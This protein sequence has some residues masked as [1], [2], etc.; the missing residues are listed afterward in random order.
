MNA[1][2]LAP[3]RAELNAVLAIA[4][5]DATKFLSDRPRI[6]STFVLPF[7]L[8]LL[9]GGSFQS[10]LGA[11]LG[12]D[13]TT[14]VFTGVFAQTL[15]QSAAMGIVS[16]LEDRENDFTQ[17]LFVAPVSRYSIILGKITGE[18]LVALAQGIGIIGFGLVVGVDLGP[19]RLAGLALVAVPICLFGGA[20]GVLMLS[21]ARSRRFAEQLFNFVFLPQ[22]FLAGVFSPLEGLPPALA[23]LSRLTPMRYAVDLVRSVFYTGSQ[24]RSLVVADGFGLNAT[25]VTVLFVICLVTGT[26]LFVRNERNR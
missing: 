26:A 8:I 6:I 25:V 22:F 24:E 14:Y 17:E 9:L 3:P 15:F 2:A 16:L 4:Q 1:R 19:A 20:F 13:F 12:F 5:R 10:S 18:A 7:F 23:V 21:L 11:S